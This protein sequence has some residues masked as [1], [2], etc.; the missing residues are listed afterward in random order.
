VITTSDADSGITSTPSPA[1]TGPDREDLSEGA[2]PDAWAFPRSEDGRLA[3]ATCLCYPDIRD[4]DDAQLAGMMTGFIDD[5]T[6][7]GPRAE[8]YLWVCETIG[9]VAAGRAE[10]SIDRLS[11]LR[12][13]HLLHVREVLGRFLCEYLDR[14]NVGA[15]RRGDTLLVNVPCPRG[16]PVSD[17][18]P[19]LLVLAPAEI[20]GLVG[21]E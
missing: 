17:G 4:D 2:S 14:A 13:Q 8:A 1:R 16:V 3:D 10:P 6:G 9:R 19:R 11:G 12:M 15:L 7:V 18:V 20:R 21:D 5:H